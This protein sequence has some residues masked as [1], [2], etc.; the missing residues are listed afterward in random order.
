MIP[1][2]FF[3]RE[4]RAAHFDVTH[5]KAGLQSARNSGIH[6]IVYICRLWQTLLCLYTEFVGKLTDL[7]LNLL[8]S[9]IFS[10]LLEDSSIIIIWELILSTTQSLQYSK[11]PI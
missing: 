4:G 8:A 2:T 6:T 11:T 3:G 10:N 7:L 9:L 1:K 5:I